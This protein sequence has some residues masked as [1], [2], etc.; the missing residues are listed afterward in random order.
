MSTL[1]ERSNRLRRRIATWAESQVL[2]M[3]EAA[4]ERAKVTRNAGPHGFAALKTQDIKLWLPS[5]LQDKG[6]EVSKDFRQYEW[7]LREGQAYDAL[8]EI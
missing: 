1:L 6:I 5:E 8:E 2:F 4:R 3:P 7:K